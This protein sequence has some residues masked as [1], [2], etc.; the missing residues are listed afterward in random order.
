MNE[1]KA[2]KFRIYPTEKQIECIH[3]SVRT[4]NFIFNYSLKQ[5]IDI[6][7]KLTEM[8]IVDKTER[9]NYMKEHDLYF[10]KFNMSRNLTQMG[11]TEE[12]SFLKNVDATS[13]SYALKAIEN[14]FKNISKMGSGF[15]KFKN[16][17]KSTYS[18][19]GQIQYLNG[20]IKSLKINKTNNKK[21]VYINLPKL[22][23]LKCFAHIP[24]FVENY[25]DYNVIKINSYTISKGG[26]N[27]Y[28][29]FQAEHNQPHLPEPI[30]KEIKKETSIGID[31]GVERP[32][33]TS[34]D[35]DF[36]LKIFKERFDI[37]KKYK[38][39]IHKLS[40]ILNRKRDYH[41]KNK[42]EIKFYDTSSYKRIS[43]KLKGLHHKIAN[44]RENLQHN[45]TSNL[46][47]KEDVDTFILEELNIKNMT[48]RS[49]KGKSNNKSNLNRVMMD[50]G[51]FGI[52]TKLSY[53]A[54]KLGKNVETIN[55]KFTSQKCSNCGHIHKLNRKSQSEF[56]CQKC[57]FTINADLNAAINIKN[58]FFNV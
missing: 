46:V 21:I 4:S 52:R 12:F 39:E 56:I 45:I 10:N 9:K 15:P 31:M 36:D 19:T 48:K 42:S 28:I 44:I 24:E 49:A 35:N 6:S 38:E 26:N 13:K 27:Y 22:K 17:H 33:T 53:K 2:Y 20:K 40:S 30:K 55:P 25:M 51:M 37:L 50:V 29:S 23:K 8:G 7:D 16:I 54:Q 14:A 5:Q 11:N 32:I 1:I 41:K 58:N 43:K 57:G 47:N 3:D 18:F 34:N